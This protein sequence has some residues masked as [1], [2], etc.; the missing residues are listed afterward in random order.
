MFL[1]QQK[2]LYISVSNY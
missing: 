2:I 1:Y